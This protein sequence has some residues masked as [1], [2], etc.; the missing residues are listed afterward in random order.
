MLASSIL[1]EGEGGGGAS[2]DEILSGDIGSQKS[3]NLEKKGSVKIE[4]LGKK[5]GSDEALGARTDASLYEVLRKNMGRLQYI[6]NSFLK[7]NANIGGKVEVE[8][9]INADGTVNKVIILS[10]A[11]P[12][13]EFEAKLKEAI[14]RWKYPLISRGQVTVVYPIVFSKI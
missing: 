7:N 5:T 3:V 9:T 12:I 6:Y 10:S 8:V 1:G 13:P 4:A 11:I 14:R 2:I